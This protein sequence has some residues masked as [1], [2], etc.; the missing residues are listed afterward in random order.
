MEGDTRDQLRTQPRQA[1]EIDT[2]RFR[3]ARANSATANMRSL[4]SPFAGD[5]SATGNWPQTLVRSVRP[6]PGRCGGPAPGGR[7]CIGFV[8]SP[9][10]SSDEKIR[11]LF[12]SQSGAISM[13]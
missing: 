4:Q 8:V 5:F 6:D 10:T 1:R 3:Q 11:A 2:K 13:R 12:A 9:S 7:V